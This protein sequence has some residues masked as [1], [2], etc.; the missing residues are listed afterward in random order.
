VCRHAPAYGWASGPPRAHRQIGFAVEGLFAVAACR[1]LFACQVEPRLHSLRH[2]IRI[3][4]LGPEGTF[5]FVDV[6]GGVGERSRSSQE[7]AADIVRCKWLS[8]SRVTVSGSTPIAAARLPA[9]GPSEP[10]APASISVRSFGWPDQI[11]DDRQR[12]GNGAVKRRVRKTLYNQR[13]IQIRH[14][15]LFQQEI[16]AEQR[17]HFELV[18]LEGVG[19]RAAFASDDLVQMRN[20]AV[21]A[22]VPP[23]KKCEGDG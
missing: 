19:D 20:P 18:D 17:G 2:G 16:A 6:D 23:T 11:A 14:P 13:E 4:R 5:G 1:H 21:G 3:R 10:A 12:N 8:T 15:C 22:I 9:S 7:R